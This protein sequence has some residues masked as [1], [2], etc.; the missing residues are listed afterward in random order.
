MSWAA[1]EERLGLPLP[2]DYKRLAATFGR[3]L[4]SDFLQRGL[5]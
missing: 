2:K 1:T 4:F 5:L 3:G